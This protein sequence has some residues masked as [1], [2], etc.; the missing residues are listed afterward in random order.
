MEEELDTKGML[1]R[2]KQPMSTLLTL[3]WGYF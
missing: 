2:Q 1:G 3:S